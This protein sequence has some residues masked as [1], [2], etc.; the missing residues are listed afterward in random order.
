ME[1][2]YCSIPACSYRFKCCTISE[3][4]RIK[5]CSSSIKS[6]QSLSSNEC[7]VLTCHEDKGGDRSARGGVFD[8]GGVLDTLENIE[9]GAKIAI[10]EIAVAVLAGNTT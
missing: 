10:M 1:I 2:T 8:T 9:V 3:N 4:L 7:V 5:V 6:N